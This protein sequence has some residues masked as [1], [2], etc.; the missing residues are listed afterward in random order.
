MKEGCAVYSFL[1]VSRSATELKSEKFSKK[2][3]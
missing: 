1:E 2:V 3:T